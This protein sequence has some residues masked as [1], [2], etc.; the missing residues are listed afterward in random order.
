MNRI[1]DVHFP[2]I[3]KR[4]VEEA[5]EDFLR[6]ARSAGPEEE[7]VDL[8]AVGTG[9]SCCSMRTS[10]RKCCASAIPEN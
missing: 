6:G 10:R 5:A 9:S 7:A 4:L 2:S 1:V 3:K 8:G